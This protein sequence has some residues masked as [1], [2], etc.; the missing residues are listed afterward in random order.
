MFRNKTIEE[1][2]NELKSEAAVPGGGA[3]AALCSSLA[4]A[5]V[6][7][8][9]RLTQDKKGYE[10]VSEQVKEIIA[11]YDLHAAEFL[12]LI[13]ED[14]GSFQKVLDAFAMPKGTDEEKAARTDAIQ[15]GLKYAA[16]VP[17]KVAEKA[18]SL[19]DTFIFLAEKGN[20]N[21]KSDILVGAM[22]A[23]TSVL[24]ALLNVKINLASIKDQDYVASMTK[25]VEA[26]EKHALD[27]EAEIL[28]N[29][30][31]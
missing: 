25:R 11:E 24:S 27:K 23:R 26:I 14:G 20:Q 28:S 2:K 3:V 19:F 8:V 10:E 22:L 12:D 7:M 17:L 9:G 21:A 31:F 13:D 30:T 18:N 6:S 29:V 16:E 4:C 15:N 1:F 5:L